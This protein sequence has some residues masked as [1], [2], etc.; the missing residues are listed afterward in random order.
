MIG[1]IVGAITSLLPSLIER[2]LPGDSDAIKRAKLELKTKEQEIKAALTTE[3]LKQQNLQLEVN[4]VEASHSS[5]FVSGWRP[6]AGWLGVFGLAWSVGLQPVISYILE[7]NGLPSLPA[8]DSDVLMTILV[9][10][11]GMGGYRSFEKLKG[12]DTK[13]I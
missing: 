7:V 12:V 13:N 10:M 8:L 9:G 3:L 4:K 5:I 6:A 11:L 2:I 1:T